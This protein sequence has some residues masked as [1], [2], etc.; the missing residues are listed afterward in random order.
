MIK[1]LMLNFYS[2]NMFVNIIYLGATKIH[3]FI[4]Q[5]IIKLTR[6]FTK[7]LRDL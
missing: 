1:S 6:C 4:A 3:Q 5:R 2:I 7:A